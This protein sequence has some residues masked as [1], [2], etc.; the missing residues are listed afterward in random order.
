MKAGDKYERLTAL[1]ATGERTH[2]RRL[3]WLFQ[4]DCGRLVTPH[5]AHVTNR[6]IRSCGCLRK[7]IISSLTRKHGHTQGYK[8][9]K[10]YQAWENA[11]ARCYNLGS[12]SYENYG[13]RG[14]RMC[15]EWETSF[16]LFLEDMGE[17]PVG[18]SLDRINNNGHYEP[19]NCKWSTRKEQA[20]NRRPRRAKA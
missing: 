20:N 1:W 10:T 6:R 17:C 7:E 8:R 5:P 4:C 15:D 18:M 3:V 9:T 13:G 16:E 19:G 14:I 2:G 11:K 12:M